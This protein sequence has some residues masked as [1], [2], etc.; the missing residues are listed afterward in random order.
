MNRYETCR[1]AIRKH[2]KFL[3]DE[4]GYG[5]KD[6]EDLGY[7]Y[8]LELVGNDRRIIL[9]YDYKENLYYFTIIR[10]IKTPYPNDKD[11][12]NIHPLWD[13][14]FKFEPNL[15]LKTLQPYEQPCA[16]A[17]QVNSRLLK[18]YGYPILRGEE[19]F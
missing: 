19:W 9:T 18:K 15:E 8:T 4:L 3:I 12:V 16:E 6:E 5:I 2:F 13:I 1:E 11:R 14:F 17:A 10:G 7:G